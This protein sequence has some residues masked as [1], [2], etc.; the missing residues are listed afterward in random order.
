MR[1]AV[2][3]IV[4]IP[5]GYWCGTVRF[6]LRPIYQDVVTTRLGEGADQSGRL[7]LKAMKRTAT[8]VAAFINKRKN[9]S[10]YH[11]P[12]WKSVCGRQ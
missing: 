1:V 10:G 5:P 2:I 12:I 11:P 4:L 6:E 9:S 8:A 7:L 3:D